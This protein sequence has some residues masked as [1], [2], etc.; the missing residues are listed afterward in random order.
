MIAEELLRQAR[1]QGAVFKVLG[2]GRI[3]I[4]ADSPLPAALMEELRQHKKDIGIL[5]AEVPDYQITACICTAPIGPTGSAICG[6]CGLALICPDCQL[7]RGCK[8]RMR[9]PLRGLC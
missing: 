2:S 9:F 3:K 5:L 6:V 4:L 7:C 1:S 8:L